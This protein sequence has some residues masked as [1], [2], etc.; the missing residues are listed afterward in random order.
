MCVCVTNP[1]EG[2]GKEEQ[3]KKDLP[4]PQQISKF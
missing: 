3:E 2:L 4:D 1:E